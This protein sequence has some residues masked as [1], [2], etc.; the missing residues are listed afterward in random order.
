MEVEK[1]PSFGY[2]RLMEGLVYVYVNLIHDEVLN[3]WRYK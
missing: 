1:S 2:V 3:I